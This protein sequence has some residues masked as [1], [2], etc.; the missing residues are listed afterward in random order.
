MYRLD[1]IVEITAHDL[2][3]ADDRFALQLALR[4]RPILTG[5]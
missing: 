2:D 3:S 1:R 4:L 5:M